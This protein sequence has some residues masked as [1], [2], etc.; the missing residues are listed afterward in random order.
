M[1]KW[2]VWSLILGLA[3]VIGISG[4]SKSPNAKDEKFVRE[5]LTA[6]YAG[7]AQSIS[8]QSIQIEVLNRRFAEVGPAT[9][10]RYGAVKSLK[11]DGTLEEKMGITQEA[12][13]VTCEKASFRL[14]LQMSDEG[15]SDKLSYLWVDPVQ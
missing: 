9:S 5:V 11:H 7:S 8:D 4:C 2:A 3:V 15:T 10:Q 12:W 14:Q 6:L 1:R 13:I